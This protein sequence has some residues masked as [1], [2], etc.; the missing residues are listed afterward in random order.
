MLLSIYAAATKRWWVGIP[1]A[2]A[3]LSKPFAIV[4]L[5]LLIVLLKDQQEPS[6]LAYLN[7]K[8][9]IR[10]KNDAGDPRE[11]LPLLATLF[12]VALYFLIQIAQAGHLIIGAHPDMSVGGALQDPTRFV[13]NLAHSLQILFSV[14]NYYFPDPALTGAGNLMHTSPVLIFLGLFG[15]LA[16]RDFWKDRHLHIPRALLLGA[17]L[18][19]V[20]N[21]LLDHMDHFYMEA[22][23]L[24]LILGSLPVLLRY[25]L[26]MFIALA[27]LH[28]QWFY[29]YLQFKDGFGL[30][31]S[32]FLVPAVVDVCFALWSLRISFS[33]ASLK[34]LA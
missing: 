10:L 27:T 31:F 9:W 14:H 23:I 16:P 26:W 29:F 12:I 24:L 32:F 6:V 25:R 20:M 19:I 3:I 22:S 11:T 34:D 15:L 5:P 13:L 7:P 2:L 1:F 4:L 17:V 8:N 30:G 28:F 33:R 18:G 21:A